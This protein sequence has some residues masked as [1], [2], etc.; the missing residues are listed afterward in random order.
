MECMISPEQG[1]KNE[2]KLRL[3]KTLIPRSKLEGGSRED[4]ELG[5]RPTAT[6]AF[7]TV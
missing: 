7:G 4:L 1:C 6:G 2:D 5:Q 3:D